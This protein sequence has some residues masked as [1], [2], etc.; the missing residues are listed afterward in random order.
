MMSPRFS[1]VT[2]TA[3]S[4]LSRRCQH[5]TIAETKRKSLRF[6]LAKAA[7]G[8]KDEACPMPKATILIVDDD[9]DS[10]EILGFVLQDAGYQVE[11]AAGTVPAIRRL[12]TSRPDLVLLDLVMP[13]LDGWRV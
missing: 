12:A 11:A 9:T 6:S 13:E 4:P 3:M 2:F 8:I 1:S 7:A 10:R 5:A